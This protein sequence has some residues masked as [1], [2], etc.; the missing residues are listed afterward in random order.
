MA[1]LQAQRKID[2]A[3]ALA[4]FTRLDELG[5]DFGAWL[6]EWL[7]SQ[8]QDAPGQVLLFPSIETPVDDRRP[9]PYG[10]RRWCIEHREE[11]PAAGCWVAGD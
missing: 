3:A 2:E 8:R 9:C 10:Q 5:G 4:N 11:P 6:N 1:D 7:H